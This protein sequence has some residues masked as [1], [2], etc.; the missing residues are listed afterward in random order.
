[1]EFLS[2]H[3]IRGTRSDS[4]AR[5]VIDVESYSE[6]KPS[7]STCQTVCALQSGL[8]SGTSKRFVSAHGCA[9]LS[10]S[11]LKSEHSDKH[12]HR[13]PLPATS[14]GPERSYLLAN[15]DTHL[16]QSQ[17][18][19]SVFIRLTLSHS[20]THRRTQLQHFPAIYAVFGCQAI[21][22]AE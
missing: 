6:L 12:T 5:V 8:V 16:S 1:M 9:A 14:A 11:A 4:C 22:F 18:H 7:I 10:L 13:M 21:H 2:A 17:T 3:M 19:K 20:H 15:G